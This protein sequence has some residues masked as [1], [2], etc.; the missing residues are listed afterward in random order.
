LQFTTEPRFIAAEPWF[1]GEQSS[2]VDIMAV[3]TAILITRIVEADIMAV[4]FTAVARLS[5]VARSCGAEL[6]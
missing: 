1:G 2:E 4:E 6:L 3:L 5:E